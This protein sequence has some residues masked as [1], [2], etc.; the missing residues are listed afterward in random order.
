MSM[1]D[2]HISEEKR[3]SLEI[4]EASR[5][6]EWKY[7]SFALKLFHGF[8]DWPLIYPFPVQ[9]SDEKRQGDEFLSK[10][11]KLL[12]EKLDPDEVDRTSTIPPEVIQ[13]LADLKAFAIKIPK[14]YG[15][16]GLSQVNY[17]RAIHLVASFCG[18]TAV[19]LSA[20]QSIGV[21]QP[22]KLFGTPEQ[23]KKYF[24]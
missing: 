16:L 15:G 20:H 6:K 5:E 3:A 7:P 2:K 4:A 13:G 10:L 24:L 22:L 9:S 18:S 14:E 19:L 1:F 17:N 8:V 12:K 21:P 11:E 23:K